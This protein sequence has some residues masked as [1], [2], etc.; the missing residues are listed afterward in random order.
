MQ[1]MSLLAVDVAVTKFCRPYLLTYVTGSTDY[2]NAIFADVSV[3]TCASF[4]W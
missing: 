4:S 3:W 2:I 1:L